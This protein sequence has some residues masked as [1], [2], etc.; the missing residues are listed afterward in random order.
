[1]KISDFVALTDEIFFEK[2]EL[3]GFAA[4]IHAG[5]SDVFHELIIAFLVVFWYDSGVRKLRDSIMVKVLIFD[6][7]GV[8]EDNYELHFELSQ[9]QITGLTREE[10]K[11]LFDGNLHVEREKLQERNTGFDLRTHF[12]A[13]KLEAVIDPEI[14][15]ALTQ[16]SKQYLLGIVSSAQ[17][18]GIHGY[19]EKNQVEHCFTFVYGVESGK[20]KSEKFEK[21]L[22]A[23]SVTPEECLFVTD[24]L[25]DIL[26]ANEAGIR[27]IAIDSGF[28]ER[29]RLEKGKPLH[30]ISR[31][32]DLTAVLLRF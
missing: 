4:A 20:L 22:S 14:K 7:D 9:K 26:E 29:E 25:G 13:K 18:Y 6:F 8:I 1:M 10:H 30:V 3:G 5:K 21:V 17:E 32:S 12:N 2:L 24:T 19:L 23:Y 31:L 28:H 27:T 15:T 16:L 11:K